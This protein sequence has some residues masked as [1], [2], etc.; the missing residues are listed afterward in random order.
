MHAQIINYCD[1]ILE[2]CRRTRACSNGLAQSVNLTGCTTLDF[3]YIYVAETRGYFALISKEKLRRLI[4][5][6][7]CK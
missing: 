4:L 5:F 1:V 3:I 7:I 2:I 6:G